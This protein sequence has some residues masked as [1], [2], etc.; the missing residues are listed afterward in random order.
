MQK[1]TTCPGGAVDVQFSSISLL[2]SRI[3]KAIVS[4]LAGEW[5][6]H[7]EQDSQTINSNILFN[8]IE[9]CQRYWRFNSLYG[10]THYV[11]KFLWPVGIVHPKTK[12]FY[13]FQRNSWLFSVLH[14]KS[15]VHTEHVDVKILWVP[16][17]LCYWFTKLGLRPRCRLWNTKWGSKDYLK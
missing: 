13:L 2:V 17:S 3:V 7:P 4:S 16:G 1:T 11:S 10:G 12:H 8:Y 9:Q 5:V 15:L 14:N 6:Q